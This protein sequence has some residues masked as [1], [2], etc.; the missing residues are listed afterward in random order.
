GVVP[1][2]ELL[3]EDAARFVAV[4]D[5]DLIPKYAVVKVPMAVKA[6]LSIATSCGVPEELPLPLA[7]Y[8]VPIIAASAM[9]TSP[10]TTAI[11]PV[12]ER[13]LSTLE[14]HFP[15]C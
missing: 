6:L 10:T 11:R 15:D 14:S 9:T 4:L 2:P 5:T 3:V 8:T 1:P 12:I 13:V 7:A